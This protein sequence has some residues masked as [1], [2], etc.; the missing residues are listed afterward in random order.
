MKDKNW[1][2]YT[3]SEYYIKYPHR[4]EKDEYNSLN[5]IAN[6]LA[7]MDPNDRNHFDDRT[8]LITIHLNKFTHKN[9]HKLVMAQKMVNKA[10]INHFKCGSL[11]RTDKVG[12]INALDYSGSRMSHS[13]DTSNSLPHLHLTLI[14]P[15][16]LYS[17][18]SPEAIPQE[19]A[20]ALIE[21]PVV[22]PY[23]I[24]SDGFLISRGIHIEKYSPVNPL[25]YTADYNGKF[26]N[27][28]N[29]TNH[30][31]I[32][33]P[34]DEIIAKFDIPRKGKPIEME[35]KRAERKKNKFFDEADSITNAL[36]NDPENIYLHHASYDW[37]S[38][39]AN[40]Q[41]NSSQEN[42]ILTN[43]EVKQLKGIQK[44][45]DDYIS[46]CMNCFVKNLDFPLATKRVEV[47][48]A[49]EFKKYGGRW[50][51]LKRQERSHFWLDYWRS[52]WLGN[53]G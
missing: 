1:L 17:Y 47:L 14:F 35:M 16:D 12:I 29:G 53:T 48:L 41:R 13:D 4:R 3:T 9:H 22:Q 36:I 42:I 25:W 7:H 33:S 45:I 26:S 20:T 10:L 38:E 34:R 24:T 50:Q 5:Q 23:E 28:T 11:E 52:I 39:S 37:C 21:L 44:I 49:H 6:A 8:Y 31:I 46:S 30:S 40:Y 32:I 15:K 18:Y 43:Q 51:W 2:N 19:I 27:K